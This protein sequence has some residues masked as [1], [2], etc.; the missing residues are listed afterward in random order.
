MLPKKENRSLERTIGASLSMALAGDG[1]ACEKLSRE[2]RKHLTVENEYFLD[3]GHGH[4][5]MLGFHN[6]DEGLIPADLV[7]DLYLQN[8]MVP[9]LASGDLPER[10]WGSWGMGDDVCWPEDCFHALTRNAGKLIEMHGSEKSGY[11]ANGL[12]KKLSL[13]KCN[14]QFQTYMNSVLDDP[15]N[16]PKGLCEV[17]FEDVEWML[18]VTPR[19]DAS[20]GPR[21]LA[22]LID[23]VNQNWN[24]SNFCVAT[25]FRA[26]HCFPGFQPRQA[27]SGALTAAVAAIGDKKFY[28]RERAIRLIV[29]CKD[30]TA[31]PALELAAAKTECDDDIRSAAAA[32]LIKLRTLS[33]EK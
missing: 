21:W 5:H 32:A 29:E 25:A 10:F 2:L 24:S 30:I 33:E 14:S 1:P 17:A 18:T 31:I 28:Y 19:S 12:R 22:A 15:G 9:W 7:L 20:L 6:S 23:Y 16:L 26:L 27:L 8:D 11:A 4:F 13:L 3:W